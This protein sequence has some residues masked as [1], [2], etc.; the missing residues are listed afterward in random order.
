MASLLNNLL[1]T[2]LSSGGTNALAE[3]TGA[4]GDQVQSVISSVLPTLLQSMTTNA[5]DEKG[6]ASLK[7][8]LADHAA[9]EDSAEEQLKN[10]DLDDGAKI[11]SHLL[12]GQQSKVEKAAA[13]S[14]GLDAA[15]VTTILA[16]VAPL[17]LNLVGKQTAKEEKKAGDSS[18]LLG[19]LLS[20][21]L[22]GSTGQASGGG[23]ADLLIGLV[24]GK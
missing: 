17:L 19:G 18:D 11:L 5:S 24:T 3:K 13:K 14:S 6:S 23:I 10:A 7:K 1:G 2:V 16:A 22:G 20:N 21:M 12:G 15:Q 9:V 8:A 4:S